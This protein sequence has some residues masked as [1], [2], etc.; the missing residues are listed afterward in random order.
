MLMVVGG[1]MLGL[2]APWSALAVGGVAIMWVVTLAAAIG[3]GSIAYR[4]PRLAALFASFAV[5][6]L[7]AASVATLGANIASNPGS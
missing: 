2:V 3:L 5:I 7:V 4:Q 6:V 1:A